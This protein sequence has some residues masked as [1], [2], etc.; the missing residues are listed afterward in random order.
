MTPEG[1]YLVKRRDGTIPEWPHFI[2]GAR[3]PCA[4]A[5]LLAYAKK[6]RELGLT[7]GY[8]SSIE[9]LAYKFEAYR[10]ENGTGDPDRGRHRPDDPAT[11][12][13]MKIGKSASPLPPHPRP[14]IALSWSKPMIDWLIDKWLGANR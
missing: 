1:K 5:A 8:A 3:D 7:S 13:E 10:M 9:R 6:A 12:T 4:K 2:I 14:P 11:V